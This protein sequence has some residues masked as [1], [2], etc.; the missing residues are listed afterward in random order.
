MTIFLLKVDDVAFYKLMNED[1]LTLLFKKTLHHKLSEAER[2]ELFFYLNDVSKEEQISQL[3]EKARLTF[4]QNA[5]PFSENETEMLK[6]SL[7]E[8]IKSLE[9][10]PKK[11]A[12]SRW[13][14]AASVTMVLLAGGIYFY[15]ENRSSLREEYETLAAHVILPGTNKATL[16]LG[17]GRTI[18]LDSISDYLQINDGVTIYKTTDGKLVYR[19]DSSMIA[20]TDEVKENVLSTPRGGQYQVELPD[21]TKVWLSAAST[22]IYPSR[23]TESTRKVS[24]VGEA[25]FE[26][27]RNEHKPFI[28]QS[29][30]AFIKVLGT[31]FLVNAYD[32]LKEMK[33]TLVEGKVQLGADSNKPSVGTFLIPGQQA[34]LNKETHQIDV[35]Q[36][37]VDDALAWKNGHFVFQHDHI[38]NVM[39]TIALWY[40][41]EVIYK[42]DLT[43]E[44]FIGTISKFE[45][46]EELLK[47]IELTGGVHFKIE[48]RKI[49]VTK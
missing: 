21:N 37:N 1:R 40:D 41:V 3:F 34:V 33:T 5:A 28:V 27:A 46:I 49:I 18:Y 32:D 7:L 23:F 22:L 31:S 16:T 44:T 9:Q 19:T 8:R 48:G 36:V 11:F 2:N 17:N 35:R 38:E 14:I 15:L 12:V 45:R 10:R 20:A 13:L 24:L 42:G 43:G 4:N 6:E 30:N 29:S 26:V 47:T 25:Y 39:K